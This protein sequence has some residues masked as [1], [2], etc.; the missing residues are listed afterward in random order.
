MCG[1]LWEI[2]DFS[3]SQAEEKTQNPIWNSEQGSHKGQIEK[4]KKKYL[5]IHIAYYFPFKSL[6][7]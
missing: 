5:G 4:E 1:S 2:I 3:V 6:Y 7:I